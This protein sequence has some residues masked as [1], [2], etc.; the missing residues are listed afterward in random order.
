MNYV[1]FLFVIVSS[2]FSALHPMF[3]W[4]CC[5]RHRQGA[6]SA[7][8]RILARESEEAA[9]RAAVGTKEVFALHA[10]P[11]PASIATTGPKG[12]VVMV[13]TDAT[14]LKRLLTQGIDLLSRSTR[15]GDRDIS[16]LVEGRNA[17]DAD[18]IYNKEDLAELYN[19]KV[20]FSIYISPRDEKALLEAFLR[21]LEVYL[22]ANRE[23][24]AKQ[25]ALA[26]YNALRLLNV[27]KQKGLKN[28]FIKAGLCT[29]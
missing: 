25:F 12:L 5:R 20:R 15:L 3:D 21:S 6:S 23:A 28:C 27:H 13:E 17:T 22:L 10:P 16:A 2:G 14:E 11:A 26:T 4:C 19:N 18:S 9:R 1:L 24:G 7:S 8:T 29:A